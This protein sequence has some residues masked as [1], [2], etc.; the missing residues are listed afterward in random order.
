MGMFKNGRAR[1]F[2][3]LLLL[4]SFGAIVTCLTLLFVIIRQQRLIAAMA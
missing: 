4:A 1:D 2:D 3:L